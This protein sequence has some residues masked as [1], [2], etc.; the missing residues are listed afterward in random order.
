MTIFP[1]EAYLGPKCE[2]SLKMAEISAICQ[3]FLH[4]H[5][6]K[7][8][9]QLLYIDHF[10][11]RSVFGAKM[12][13][14]I[15]VGRNFCHMP[16]ISVPSYQEKNSEHFSDSSFFCIMAPSPISRWGVVFWYSSSASSGSKILAHL[17]TLSMSAFG[18]QPSKGGCAAYGGNNIQEVSCN[19][20]L[21]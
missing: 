20:G 1:L 5:I 16:E 21:S 19:Y 8:I 15:K 2:I 3:K 10:P 6:Q 11:S 17:S 18:G 9:P 14:F 4:P 13:N 7:K 12:K